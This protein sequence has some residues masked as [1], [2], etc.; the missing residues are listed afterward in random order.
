MGSVACSLGKSIR[1]HRTQSQAEAVNTELSMGGVDGRG[2]RE[3]RGER[4]GSNVG[5]GKSRKCGQEKE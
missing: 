1:H 3:G 4:A 5:K 2:M